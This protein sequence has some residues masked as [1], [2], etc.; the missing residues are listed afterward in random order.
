MQHEAIKTLR[1]LD[2]DE[3]N[4]QLQGVAYI[5]MASPA[6]E[7]FTQTPIHFT[8]FLNTS[9]ALPD[10]IKEAVF[11]KFLKDEAIFN[12]KEVLAAVMPVGFSEGVHETHMP[13]LL[14]KNEDRNA[15]PH[16]PMFVFDF[17][18][19]SNNFTEAKEK[20]LT[21]WSYIYE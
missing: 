15:I 3:I 1:Y 21:G 4:K 12:P 17:L 14:V 13:M 5:I 9:H 10:G 7:Q 11:E 16:T 19:D 18:A 2:T 6:P 20:S 8:L